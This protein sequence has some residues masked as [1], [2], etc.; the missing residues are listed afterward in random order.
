MDAQIL[1]TVRDYAAAVEQEENELLCTLAQIPAPSG[2]EGQR[3]A[4]VAEWLR[5]AGC[6]WTEVD[7]ANNV[8][9]FLGN[10][11]PEGTEPLEVFSAHTDVVFDDEDE[12]PLREEDGK[13][14]C[15]GIGDDTANLVGLMMAARLL[16]S[17]PK[18]IE[19]RSVLVVANSCEEGL[20]N[21]RG[22]R[23]LYRR[24]GNRIRSHI[25]FDTYT[26]A[27]VSHA[28]GSERWRVSVS[29]E[30]GHSW[31]C[32]GK[33]NA[34]VELSSL[35]SDLAHIELPTDSRTTWNV[36]T[37]TGGS[38]INS[39]AEHAQ[40]LYEYRSGSSACLATMRERFLACVA[41]HERDG[42][43]IQTELVGDRP[44][45]ADTPIA[46][47]AELEAQAIC[48]LREVAGMEPNVHPS[49]T[50]AN[51]PLS[52]GIPALCV[53][54][55]RGAGAH[56]REEWIDPSSLPEGLALICAL[57]LGI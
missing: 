18:L 29:C 46:G 54:A 40:M 21:L 45:D 7:E 17:T 38:T 51:I 9:C 57:M 22:T 44:A 48:M 20:G 55:V 3:A 23:E 37:I 42:V 13:L 4:F 14:W 33:P 2:K 15:P 24:F 34:I 6:T 1:K 27:I 39:I 50:D 26:G 16:A 25:T 31:R 53:G 19:G 35:I 28:V 10:A 41:A 11:T 8:L 47:L 32:F 12:L 52:L 56:T 36:G 5:S 43:D 30:G 49:S